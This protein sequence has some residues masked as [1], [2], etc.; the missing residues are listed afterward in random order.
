MKKY[1]VTLLITGYQTLYV[2]AKD[3]DSA[4]IIA[5]EKCD[6]GATLENVEVSEWETEADEE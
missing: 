3:A 1:S 6:P 2:E 5:K 4:F